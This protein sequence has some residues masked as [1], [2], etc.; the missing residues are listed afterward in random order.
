MFKPV[1]AEFYYISDAFYA[2]FPMKT[3]ANHT[4]ARLQKITIAPVML[5]PLG[6]IE[7]YVYY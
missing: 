1:F 5:T 2:N 6:N 3:V 7:S 4:K